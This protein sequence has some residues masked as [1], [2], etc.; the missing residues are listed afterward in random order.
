MRNPTCKVV[1]LL[2]LLVLTAACEAGTGPGAD[3]DGA[4]GF[5]S[6]AL[7]GPTECLR[8]LRLSLDT[9]VGTAVGQLSATDRANTVN[10]LAWYD[11]DPRMLNLWRGPEG[12]VRHASARWL[13]YDVA[14]AL[15]VG[16][17]Q[18]RADAALASGGI[19]RECLALTNSDTLSFERYIPMRNGARR[20]V[21]AQR[22]SGLRVYGAEAHVVLNSAGRM[23][24]ID[25][26]VVPAVVP[27]TGTLI[28]SATALATATAHVQSLGGDWLT[29]P[30][31]NATTEEVVLNR[32]ESSS[33]DDERR[34]WRF[35]LSAGLMVRREVLVDRISNTV[36]VSLDLAKYLDLNDTIS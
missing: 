4:V 18:A 13:Q 7:S 20:F 33:I 19:A 22:W 11:E 34:V 17:T 21:Y 10:A 36:A 6:A 32:L 25:S 23:T 35:V 30:I 14:P 31:V 16:A 26:T 28:S 27:A 5:S 29:N 3:D 8:E 1:A 9:S 24:R 12:Q 15:P 2:A